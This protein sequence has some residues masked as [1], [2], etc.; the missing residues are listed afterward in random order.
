MTDDSLLQP[1]DRLIALAEANADRGGKPFACLV[2]RD[3]Q[4]L[5][6]SPNLVV[7]TNDPTAHAEILA[8][9]QACQ[10][11]GS[12]ELSG[13]EVWALAE[14]CPM[15]LGALYYAAPDRFVYLVTREQEAQHYRDDGR[16]VDMDRFYAEYALGVDQRR[17]PMQHEPRDAGVEVYRRWQQRQG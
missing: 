3:G 17:L 9:R 4:V 1:A 5:A 12:P 10:R 8:V 2:L 11:L 7:Q 6:E 14:P 15:C 16:W 13:C